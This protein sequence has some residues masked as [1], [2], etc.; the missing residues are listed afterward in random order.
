MHVTPTLF[1]LT[2]LSGSGKTTLGL[3]LTEELRAQGHSVI[4]L[5]GDVLR[6]LYNNCFGHE[7]DERLVASLQYARLCKFLLAQ[8]VHVVCSTISL[9][10]KTQIWNRE[11]ISRYIEI[12]LDVSLPELIERDNKG[13]YSR[14][15]KGELKNIVGVDI[16]PEFP[17]HPDLII[18]NAQGS[19]VIDHVRLILQYIAADLKPVFLN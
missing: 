6:E 13:I 15:L 11:N 7:R 17:M 3:L 19:S 1:W 18:R 4:F 16:Q 10:H 12:F 5:D 9:F 2:G 8:G 14:G